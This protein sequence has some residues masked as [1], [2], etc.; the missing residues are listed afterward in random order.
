M[1]AKQKYYSVHRVVGLDVSDLVNMINVKEDI[2]IENSPS[3][4]CFTKEKILVAY[5]A[6]GFIPLTLKCLTTSRVCLEIE[7]ETNEGKILR[8]L[9]SNYRKVANIP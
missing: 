5:K 8:T 6:I 4:N 3:N 2:L 7:G 9:Q 1:L